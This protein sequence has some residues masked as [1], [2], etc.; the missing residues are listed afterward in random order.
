MMFWRRTR[1]AELE[2]SWCS[3][4]PAGTYINVGLDMCA[5]VVLDQVMVMKNAIMHVK[6][7]GCICLNNVNPSLDTS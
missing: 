6:H 3:G 1:P 7:I 2:K 4:H 5:S